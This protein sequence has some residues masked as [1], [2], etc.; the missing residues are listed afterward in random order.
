MTP[1]LC[2]EG[3]KQLFDLGSRVHCLLFTG[4][5]LKVGVLHPLLCKVPYVNRVIPYAVPGSLY[6]NP[7]GSET[8]IQKQV[9]V[10]AQKRKTEKKRKFFWNY[11]IFFRIQHL[12]VAHIKILYD[13]RR[14]SPGTQHRNDLVVLHLTVVCSYL[15]RREIV[16]GCWAVAR[17]SHWSAPERWAPAWESRSAA[18]TGRPRYTDTANQSFVM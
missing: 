7:N 8:E 18:G 10:S 15:T 6:L 5:Y 2:S 9:P 11:L 13:Q 16:I 3:N 12:L 1:Q 14:F 4:S 17:A